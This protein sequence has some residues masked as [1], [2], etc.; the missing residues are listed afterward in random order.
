MLLVFQL[1]DF[2]LELGQV[3]LVHRTTDKSRIRAVL[4]RYY[5]RYTKLSFLINFKSLGHVASQN[6]KFQLLEAGSPHFLRFAGTDLC[7]I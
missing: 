5:S 4:R 2:D 1:P 3:P 7:Q 6:G